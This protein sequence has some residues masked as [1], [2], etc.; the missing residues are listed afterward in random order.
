MLCLLPAVFMVASQALAQSYTNARAGERVRIDQ[1]GTCRIVENN[2]PD[3]LMIP[4]KSA[5]EWVSGSGAF[6]NKIDSM[7]NVRVFGCD[8]ASNMHPLVHWQATEGHVGVHVWLDGE[9]DVVMRSSW[10]TP[11]IVLPLATFYNPDTGQ[12]A[13]AKSIIQIGMTTF[14]AHDDIY[15]EEFYVQ[16]CESDGVAT[17]P[18]PHPS[19]EIGEFLGP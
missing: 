13:P 15:R 3:K 16:L 10:M 7:K 1:H 8:I 6:L 19:P 18:T 9:Y 17:S 4:H 14:L 12:C 5:T 2:N 11:G